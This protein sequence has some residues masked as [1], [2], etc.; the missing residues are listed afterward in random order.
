MAARKTPLRAAKKTQPRKAKTRAKKP[1]QARKIAVTGQSLRLAAKQ[2]EIEVRRAG[3]TY[4]EKATELE[5]ARIRRAEAEDELAAFY[6]AE[7]M[8]E[9]RPFFN[10]L[11]QGDSWFD[12]ACGSAIIHSLQ[13]LFTPKNAYFRNIAA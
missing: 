4:I 10:F 8:R 11:A 1:P 2:A 5:L 13:A 6:A 7:A 12:Y 9:K 3:K